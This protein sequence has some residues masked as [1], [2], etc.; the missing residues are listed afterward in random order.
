MT[1]TTLL[2]IGLSPIYIPIVLIVLGIVTSVTS[3]ICSILLSI[4]IDLL[5]YLFIRKT[6]EKP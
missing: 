1:V 2:I 3:H 5:K 4:Y 6:E